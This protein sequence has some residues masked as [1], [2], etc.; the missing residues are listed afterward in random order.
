[1]SRRASR[2]PPCRISCGSPSS[3]RSTRR[4]ARR[5]ASSAT[6]CPRP[7][8][9][10]WKLAWRAEPSYVSSKGA[11][12]GGSWR[13]E[14]E[15][16]ITGYCVVEEFLTGA[17]RGKGYAKLL[18]QVL[19]DVLEDAGDSQLWGTVHAHNGPSLAAARSVGRGIREG[20]WFVPMPEGP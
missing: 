3:R 8:G 12:G 6:R 19:I 1:M 9:P 7:S 17:A 4:G 20:W 2:S 11:R 14:D 13:R 5:R 15:R 18:Q 10:S 16:A